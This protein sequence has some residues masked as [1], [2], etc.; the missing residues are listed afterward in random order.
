VSDDL[1]ALLG[2]KR[3]AAAI[4]KLEG[5][6]NQSGRA[7]LIGAGC[8]KC[9]GLPLTAE[10]TNKVFDDGGLGDTTRAILSAIREL[11]DGAANA[12]I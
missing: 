12:N 8:S 11:F 9:A 2:D 1:S 7:F 4:E 5:L 6:L 3:F 10:L